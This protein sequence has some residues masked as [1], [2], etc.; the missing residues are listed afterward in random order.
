[1]L[2]AY[3]IQE[4][5]NMRAETKPVVFDVKYA[6]VAPQDPFVN[7]ITGFIIAGNT[8]RQGYGKKINV[9]SSTRNL[10]YRIM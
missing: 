8:N 9:L 2:N 5:W 6:N 10:M 4:P 3:K 7:T 1:M